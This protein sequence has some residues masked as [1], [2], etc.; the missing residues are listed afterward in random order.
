MKCDTC[1]KEEESL[2][3]VVIE[4]NYVVSKV[5]IPTAGVPRLY[6]DSN[7]ST[8]LP[9]WNRKQCYDGNKKDHGRNK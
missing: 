3:R 9:L 8:R 4:R 5:Y 2:R 6:R 7:A 1:G